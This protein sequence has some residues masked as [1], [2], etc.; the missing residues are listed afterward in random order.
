MPETAPPERPA[1]D[2]RV[3]FFGTWTAIHA[4]VALSAVLVMVLLALFSRWPF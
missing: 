4:A 2:D 1:A 3:P